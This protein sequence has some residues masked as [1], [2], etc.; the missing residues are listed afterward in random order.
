M[1]TGCTDAFT[2][3]RNFVCFSILLQVVAMM[4]RSMRNILTHRCPLS[5]C[6]VPDAI[7]VMSWPSTRNVKFLDASEQAV[8]VVR[9]I[10]TVACKFGSLERI[11]A[12]RLYFHHKFPLIGRFGFAFHLY[13]RFFAGF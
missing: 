13:H 6:G 5:L 11:M 3:Q 7:R 10:A 8:S 2:A 12:S 4:T 1:K 9:D